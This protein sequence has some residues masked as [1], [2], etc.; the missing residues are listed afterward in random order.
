MCIYICLCVCI[1]THIYIYIYS[2]P[3]AAIGIPGALQFK[4]RVKWNRH[5]SPG[6][7]QVDW[8]LAHKVSSDHSGL[9]EAT[10]S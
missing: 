2:S 6:S 3:A 9:R 10:G 7:P 4:L 1:Y 5:Q 8:D